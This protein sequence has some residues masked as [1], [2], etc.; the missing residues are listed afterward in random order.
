M[1]SWRSALGRRFSLISAAAEADAD[2]RDEVLLVRSWIEVVERPLD[3][4]SG[5]A[6]QQ[7][8]LDV[9]RRSESP[10]RPRAL[11]RDAA[12]QPVRHPDAEFGPVVEIATLPVAGH[13]EL[14]LGV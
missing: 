12:A 1:A 14:A 6:D 4:R 9:P 11:R 3:S 5:D 10:K 8:R 7:S 13:D 2:R